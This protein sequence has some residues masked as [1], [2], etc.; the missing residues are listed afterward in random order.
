MIPAGS[1]DDDP[2]I[3]VQARIFGKSR[4][5][6]SCDAQSLPEFDEYPS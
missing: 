2:G 1:L 4:A 5:P 6:W 3:G